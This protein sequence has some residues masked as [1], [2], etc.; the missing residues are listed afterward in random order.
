MTDPV[1]ATGQILITR[2]GELDLLINRT[3]NAPAVDVWASLTEPERVARWIGHWTGDAAPGRT[4]SFV[5]SAEDGAEPE[6]VDIH[7]CVR[8]RRLVVSF[9]Q[10]DETQAPW[11]VALDLAESDGRTT[12]RF[13][14]SVADSL[15]A[16]DIGPGWEYYLD[17]LGADVA[18][19]PM[20]E[21]DA[22]FPSQQGYYQDAIAHARETSQVGS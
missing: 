11:R 10:A 22:Y 18:G 13:S 20:P 15:D 17:R 4:I 6:Q 3:F 21:F 14:T 19:Q 7:E 1:N 16:S 2:L 5:M 9:R 8:E 12:V